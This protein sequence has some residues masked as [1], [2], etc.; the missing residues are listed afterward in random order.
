MFFN[1]QGIIDIDEMVGKEPSFQKIMD[2]DIVT[3]D[4]LLKQS[5]L[6]IDLLHETEQRFS[7]NDQEFIKRLFVEANVLSTVYHIH[8]L[9]N[10]R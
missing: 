2:D 4:E 7:E 1:K 9:Q 8:S 5:Q 6:V 10:I 3:D